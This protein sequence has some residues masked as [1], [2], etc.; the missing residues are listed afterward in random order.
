MLDSQTRLVLC[1][2]R[3]LEMYGLSPEFVMPGRTLREIVEHRAEVGSFHAGDVELY[4]AEIADAVSRR[5]GFSKVT[6]LHDGRIISIVNEPMGGG[7][8]VATH[9]DITEAKRAEGRI[10]QAAC[11]DSLTGLP[12]R[13]VFC[14]QLE[15][16][17]KRVQRGERLAVLY[18]DL[19]HMKQ[20]NDTLGHPAGDKLLMVVADRLRD[21]V[22]DIDVVAR[23]SGDEFAIIQKCAR[24]TV[25]CRD[26]GHA[27]SRCNSRTIRI[28]MA[29]PS[30]WISASEF[31]SHQMTRP[32]L[33]EIDENC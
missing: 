12:N 31:P 14:E 15:Q 29:I 28:S 25:R 30:R 8:W 27:S 20:V 19:D 18:L 26:A 2:N 5:K 24:S 3:Y 23:L 11:V 1:N 7:G 22:R 33:D 21:C 17:L 10:A 6:R 4:L 16:E 13:E 32:T 9:E